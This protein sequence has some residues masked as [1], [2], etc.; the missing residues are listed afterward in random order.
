MPK[1]KVVLYLSLILDWVALVLASQEFEKVA[2]YDIPPLL[3]LIAMLNSM[4]FL[5]AHEL[6]HK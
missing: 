6:F 3:F 4:S 2:W 1:F 5:V